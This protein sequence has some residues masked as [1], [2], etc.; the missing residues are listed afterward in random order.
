LIIS[1]KKADY[2]KFRALET[3]L[4]CQFGPGGYEHQIVP[5]LTDVG[6]GHPILQ[7]NHP[8][9]EIRT[10]LS[11][12]SPI[13]SSSLNCRPRPGSEIILV[14][15]DSPSTDLPKKKEEPLLIAH[16]IQDHKALLLLGHDFYRWDLG[17]W[18]VGETNAVFHQLISNMVRWL[19]TPTTQSRVRISTNRS[20][21]HSGEDIH[22]TAEVYDELMQP[23]ENGDVH[24]KLLS[25]SGEFQHQL[26]G[27]G[28]GRYRKTIQVYE[29][30]LYRVKGNA[31]F[32][33]RLLGVG[34]TEFSITSFSPDMQVT[35]ANP[36]LMRQLARIT[37]GQ[38]GSGNRIFDILKGI[39]LPDRTVESTQE[40]EL[41]SRPLTLLVL[42]LLL[43]IEWFIRK[44]RGML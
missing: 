10:A 39:H 38:F 18:G 16:S 11:K 27:L 37:G 19:S 1:G 8:G 12:L 33:G 42:I 15:E 36:S 28:N 40:I 13:F 14:V 24:V 2:Q 5:R 30:G 34:E 32:Q 4:E 44:R 9:E 17:M 29:H 7:M 20:V 6:E 3:L 22:L 35:T 25:P 31:S 43:T 26:A 23:V 21:F 41:Y